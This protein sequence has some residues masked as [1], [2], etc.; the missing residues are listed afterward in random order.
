[1]L[2]QLGTVHEGLVNALMA[3]KDRQDV[4]VITSGDEAFNYY[5][6]EFLRTAQRKD[7][8][9]VSVSANVVTFSNNARAIFTTLAGYHTILGGG[10]QDNALVLLLLPWQF[11]N[12]FGFE[13]QFKLVAPTD[14]LFYYAET[15]V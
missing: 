7:V 12:L 11:V 5:Q 1:M 9:K 13:A 2:K 6:R 15:V 3:L 4:V 10:L 14:K 8:G